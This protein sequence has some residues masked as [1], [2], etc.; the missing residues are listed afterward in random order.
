[1][2]PQPLFP[3]KVKVIDL[4]LGYEAQPDTHTLWCCL[5]EAYLVRVRGSHALFF[6]MLNLSEFDTFPVLSGN[7]MGVTFQ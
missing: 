5:A 3:G 6:L 1:M 7:T 2:P 4:A